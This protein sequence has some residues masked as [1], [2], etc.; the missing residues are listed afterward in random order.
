MHTCQLVFRVCCA[1]DS[2]MEELPCSI[3]RT[4]NVYFELNVLNFC[5]WMQLLLL[6]MGK[7][8]KIRDFC[9]LDDEKLVLGSKAFGYWENRPLNSF[10]GIWLFN[11]LRQI[12][13]L[14]SP[15]ISNIMLI[16]SE[17][18]GQT[19]L[20]CI[21]Y[22]FFR[23]LTFCMR[24]IIYFINLLLHYFLAGINLCCK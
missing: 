24:K 16:I 12:E 1:C 23:S 22:V 2:A 19:S 9:M 4:C 13:D 10:L 3:P 7:F 6:P 14:R 8:T 17:Y 21:F 15:Y 20:V 18:V 11:I 5:V